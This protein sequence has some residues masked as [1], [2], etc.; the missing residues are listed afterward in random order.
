MAPKPLSDYPR[1]PQDNGRGVHWSAS[2]YHPSGAD[3]Q[4]W[5]DELKAMQIKWVKLLDDGGGSSIELCRA[6]LDNDM[7]PVVRV[8]RDRP[9]PGHIGGREIDAIQRLIDAGVRYFETNNEPDLPAEW[10]D[11]H[12]P[13]NWLD[14]VVDNF[15][16]DADII[17]GMGGL[18]AFPAMGPGSK[19]NGLAKV[20]ERGRLD[21]FEKGAWLAI[22]NYTLNHPLDYP[23]DPVNQEGQPLTQEEYE[24]LAAW[25][26]SHLTWEEIQEL[27]IPITRED[28]DKFNRWAWDGRS[29]EEINRIRAENKNPG[30]T[31]FDDASCF[32]AWE[33][34]GQLM[35]ESLGFY[36]PIIST[37]GGPVV[38]WGDDNR[39]AKVNPTT[40]AEWQMRIV[41]FLQDEAPPWYFSVCTW[42]LA[43]KP[44]G[45]FN[46]TWDQMSWYT[47]AWDLQ[48]GLDGQLP[49]VQLLKDTPAK[50]RHELRPEED[51]AAVTG[52]ITDAQ[53]RP[54]A[55]AALELRDAQGVTM[56]RDES[57]AAGHFEL[58][59]PPGVYD[60]FVPWWGPVARD[61][62]LTPGDVDVIDV[63]GIDPPG[64]Y[65][66][67]G[68]VQDEDGLALPEMPVHI[69]RHG[70]VHQTVETDALGE[71]TFHPALAGTYTL[72]TEGASAEVAVTPEAP[73]ARQDLILAPPP[74][75]RYVLVEKRLLPP[76]E[77]GNREMFY[78]R[79][80]NA[81]GEGM[82][83][84]E[85]EM[86][87]E[88]ADPGTQ[89]P[90]TQTGRDPFKPDGYYEFIHTKGTFMIQVV[91][92]D[93]E[94]DIADGLETAQVPG[95]EGEPIT[96]EVNFQLLPVGEGGKESAIRGSAPGGRA[97]QAVALWKD[98]QKTAETTLNHAR[99]FAFEH[100][101]PGV[102]DVELTG[103]GLIATELHLDG[104]E[105]V[106][107][108]FPL[109]GAI[110]G[111]VE[112]A[113]G[114][115]RA[116][117]LISETYGFI[118]HG[119]LT[120]DGQYRFTN[121][122][123]GRYRIELGDDILSGLETDGKSVTEAPPLRVGAGGE[124]RHSRIS[125]RVHDAADRPTPHATISLH[126]QGE[127]IA[128]TQSGVD[129]RYAFEG[130]GPGVYKVAIGN[131]VSVADIVLDGE[132]EVT[133]DLLYAPIAET[134]AKSL[135][136][137]YLL[138][139]ADDALAPE[140]MRL[141][142]P[143]LATQPAGPAGFSLT[144]AQFAQT[145]I[146][147]GDGIP[148]S[149]VALLQDA[150]CEIIDLRGGLL[151]LAR[152][153]ANEAATTE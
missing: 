130:L 77:T 37:E 73:V 38:G 122:P 79:V 91:Q 138:R 136:R 54:L 151:E 152:R 97:G 19:D 128:T 10:R 101:G 35:Y 21:I 57:D 107:L 105:Q 142:A 23:Y 103:V 48:F 153:L 22:H 89:F 109:M 20:V 67:A 99:A 95:R 123:A 150:Q 33:L 100:L 98:G 113:G 133:V 145:V 55:G 13:D 137:Y 40:Q 84:V 27:G 65:E 127:V 111:R 82:N 63:K 85:L 134:P 129:G 16:Y 141:V 78:G 45:D 56:A 17:Q 30:D 143:W 51:A 62:T 64:Q 80:L 140:L 24:R 61:I 44:L 121:L 108:L 110:V 28:Y 41:E 32:R 15:I 66:I 117:K 34:F 31:I 139:M 93:Y 83:G 147:L 120:Q 132:N 50:I 118:R 96:Y 29:L 12:R 131:E 74:T 59:A 69:Q 104:R 49:I 9:N 6:L 4:F 94:S 71:F 135:D 68:K 2:V 90:R 8:Y 47:H 60:L 53:G 3:L 76:E 126:F 119:E 92:G 115:Q 43:S 39:Y 5:I 25:Q 88:H 148:E 102:Y 81:A 46:P 149:V 146:L 114:E 70:V 72:T 36:I 14:I 144:E 106:T 125:G 58:T 75:M 124:P 52:A 1:P 26:Y 11:N 18:P 86:R 116:V 112:G 87:W 42:L 7:M